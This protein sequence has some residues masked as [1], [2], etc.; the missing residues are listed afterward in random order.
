MDN[1]RMDAIKGRFE[2]STHGDWKVYE[3]N[4]GVCIG[5]ALDHPQLKSPNP[6]V[7]M[8][9]WAEAPHK[10][11]Y[12]RKEDAVFI[13]HAKKDMGFLLQKVEYLEEEMRRLTKKTD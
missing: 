6:V 3:T 5:T 10:R 8:S 4:E 1:T 13:A 7:S 12:M 11:I 2:D 9:T